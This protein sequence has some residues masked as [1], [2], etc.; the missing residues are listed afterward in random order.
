LI[1]ESSLNSPPNK[2]LNLTRCCRAGFVVESVSRFLSHRSAQHW[3]PAETFDFACCLSVRSLPRRR[4]GEPM[5]YRRF[6]MR[7]KL[8]VAIALACSWSSSAWSA[9]AGDGKT[10]QGTWL[11]TAA[12]LGGGK[13]PDEVRKTITLSIKGDKY[14]VTVGKKVDK[15]TVKMNASAKP[16]TLDI[17][18][19]E[20]PNKGRTILAIYELNGD[21]L[22]VCYDLSGKGRPKKFETRAGTQLFLVTYK[23]K[24]N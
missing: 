13:F 22:R 18:G 1:Q 4:I 20:G 5:R 9:D 14:T 19:T 2:A 8:F 23:R 15:G 7:V 3:T 17:T 11:P 24:K 16:K 6:P 21:T 10:I 12:E